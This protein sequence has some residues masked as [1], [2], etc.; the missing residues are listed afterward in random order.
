MQQTLEQLPRTERCRQD[1]GGE[2]PEPR[3]R[4][5]AEKLMA[6]RHNSIHMST[7]KNEAGS[8]EERSGDGLKRLS[9]GA[10]GCHFSLLRP[11]VSGS[12]GMSNEGPWERQEKQLFLKKMKEIRNF[13]GSLEGQRGYG[14]A[15]DRKGRLSPK[16]IFQRVYER[17][18]GFWYCQQGLSF[19]CASIWS[20]LC[21]AKTNAVPRC[22]GPL[23]YPRWPT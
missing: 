18:A 20:G 19:S 1:D 6:A 3:V 2:D 16:F 13:S 15:G 14:L 22:F 11:R 9:G 17:P 8:D 5:A 4:S 12:T 21:V 7:Q 10:L 23:R